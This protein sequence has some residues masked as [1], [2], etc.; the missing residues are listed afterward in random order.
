MY[1]LGDVAGMEDS[2]IKIWD[3]KERSNVA[4]L[5]GHCGPIRCIAFSENGK[6]GDGVESE[7]LEVPRGMEAV[8]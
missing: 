2:M 5:P 6:G 3:L 7:G 8:P 4:N 1:H